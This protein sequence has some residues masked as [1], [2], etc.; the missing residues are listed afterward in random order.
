MVNLLTFAILRQITRFLEINFTKKFGQKL[1]FDDSLS[2]SLLNP[3]IKNKKL[4][5]NLSY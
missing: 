1:G 3:A 2:I 5:K 4:K